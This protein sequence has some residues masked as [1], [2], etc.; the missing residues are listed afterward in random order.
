MA[1]F[2]LLAR[3]PE[4]FVLR[5][6]IVI[7]SSKPPLFHVFQ[8]GMTIHIFVLNLNVICSIVHFNPALPGRFN[9]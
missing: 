2:R 9:T 3:V 7:L 8:F 4:P 5:M 1:K 6:C